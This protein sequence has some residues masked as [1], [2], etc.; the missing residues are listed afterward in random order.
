MINR[1]TPYFF[2]KV[3][4][5]DRRKFGFVPEAMDSD[6]VIWQEKAYIDFYQTTQQRGI[7]DR[8]SRMAYPV[9]GRVDFGDKHVLEV[10][11]GI[12]RHLSY[13]ESKPARYTICD[14]N[15]DVL[16][17]AEKQ[18]REATIPRET[19]LLSRRNEEELPFANESFDVIISFNSLEH[20]HPLDIYLIEIKRILK[21]GGQ[22]VGGI[23]CEGGLAWG[24]GRFFTTRRYVHKNYGIN[25]DKII[26]WEHPNFADIIIE[27]LDT[28]FERQYLKSHPFPW[29]PIDFNLVASF[30]FVR[31]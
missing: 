21:S 28:H 24:L 27:R 29:L 20:L 11:P 7:G 12:I 5:G 22:L 3:L 9:I 18:L 19:I 2:S 8:V 26:C 16:S 17:M 31:R 15:E 14:I 4:W 6:W 1:W 10:G 30:I 13:V 25:Y 23:P